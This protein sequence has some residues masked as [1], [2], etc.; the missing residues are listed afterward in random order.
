MPQNFYNRDTS[1]LYDAI[2]SST[3]RLGIIQE[4]MNNLFTVGYKSL[5]P[6][7]V[8]FSQMMKDMFRDESQGELTKT[9]RKLDFALADSNAFFLV[10]GKDGP[11]RTRDGSF[12]VNNEGKLV[13]FEGKELV[14]LDQ[15]KNPGLL[16]KLSES[17]DFFVDYRGHIYLDGK[18]AGRIAVDYHSKRLGQSTRI[19]QGN[20]EASNV[21]LSQNIVKVMEIK[22]HIENLEGAM[23]MEMVMDK[24]LVET[25]GRNV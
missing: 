19:I 14:V 12:H 22:R 1:T 20:L 4:N 15:D 16:S 24:S 5:D 3:R 8:L 21:D 2:H 23:A 11:E 10:E 9:N 6:D 18:L 25:Y 17:N 7:S 13:N